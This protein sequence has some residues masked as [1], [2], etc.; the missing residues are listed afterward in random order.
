MPLGLWSCRFRVGDLYPE[1]L[2]VD[3]V[4]LSIALVRKR[5]LH[6]VRPRGGSW[7]ILKV[8]CKWSNVVIRSQQTL[9]QLGRVCSARKPR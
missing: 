7:I 6:A 1:R 2:P 9:W 4:K 8:C 3:L 5:D